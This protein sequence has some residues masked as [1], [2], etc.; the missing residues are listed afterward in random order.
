MNIE[1]PFRLTWK[2]EV[3]KPKKTKSKKKQ[4]EE[5]TAWFPY[6]HTRDNHI[7]RIKRDGAKFIRKS[8]SKDT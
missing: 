5:H 1:F 3:K 4:Y 2:T 8:M 7:K 6:E